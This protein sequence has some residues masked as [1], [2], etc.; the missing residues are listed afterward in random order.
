[1]KRGCVSTTVQEYI[2]YTC[3]CISLSCSSCQI[4][5]ITKSCLETDEQKR[6]FRATLCFDGPHYTFWRTETN[7]TK[8]LFHHGKIIFLNILFLSFWRSR[9]YCLI[10]RMSLCADWGRSFLATNECYHVLRDCFEYFSDLLNLCDLVCFREHFG[11]LPIAYSTT[12][13]KTSKTSINQ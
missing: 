10:G 8:I 4:Y 13:I 5:N 1:M 2:L 11:S 6:E 9:T 3:K 12:S 7:V